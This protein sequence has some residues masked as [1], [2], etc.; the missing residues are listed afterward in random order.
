MIWWSN[1]RTKMTTPA[2]INKLSKLFKGMCSKIKKRIKTKATLIYQ[3]MSFTGDKFSFFHVD[4]AYSVPA[5][6]NGPNKVHQKIFLTVMCDLEE[7]SFQASEFT[8]GAEWPGIK[9]HISDP[10]CFT[11]VA[12]EID[13]ICNLRMRMDDYEKS[14]IPKTGK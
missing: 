13:R 11:K 6:W 12:E 3:G 4:A 14:L 2:E 7:F 8:K 5:T 10:K 1:K 9:I